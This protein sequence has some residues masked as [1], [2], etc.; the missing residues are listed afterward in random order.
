MYNTV[1]IQQEYGDWLNVNCFYA[2]NGFEKLGFDVKK[3]TSDQ[4][5]EINFDNSYFFGGIQTTRKIFDALNVKQPLIHNLIDH[6]TNYI[7]RN[8]YVT[9]LGEV[10]KMVIK[11][12]NPIFIKPFEDHK[13]FTGFVVKN[14][15]L[16][17]MSVRRFADETKIILSEVVNFETEYRCFILNKQIVGM[18]NYTGDYTKIIDYSVVENAINDYVDQPVSYTLDFGLVNNETVLIEINDGFAFGSYGL[19]EITYVKMIIARMDQIL[20]RKKENY[21]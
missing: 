18:K 15:L 4:V 8:M 1:Y 19:N 7:H 12:D 6:L 17:L 16:G 10:R 13:L 20:N 11:P 21:I 14:S 9:T 5:P 3:F 2:K